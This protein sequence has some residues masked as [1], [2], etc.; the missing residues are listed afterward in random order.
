MDTV[1]S[2]KAT[3]MKYNGTSWEDVGSAGFSAGII[4]YPSISIDSNNTPYVIY[5]DSE[6]GGKVTVMK[7]YAGSWKNV[8]SAGFSVSTSNFSS[9]VIDTNNTPYVVYKD[10]GYGG[11]AVVMKFEEG[12]DILTGTPTAT[13]GAQTS[14][15]VNLTLSDGK[16]GSTIHSFTINISGLNKAPIVKNGLNIVNSVD[17][18][19]SE[20]SSPTPFSLRL[21]ATDEE[22]DTIIWSIDTNASN[23]TATIS[24]STTSSSRTINYI[25][26]K[27]FNGTDSFKVKVIAGSTSIINVNVNVEAEDDAPILDSISSRSVSED[28]SSFNINLNANDV[29]GDIIEYTAT[30]SNPDIA[31]VSIVDGKVIVT[32]KE[33]ANGIVTVTVNA[34]ANGKTTSKNFNVDISEVN[35]TPSI[36]TI[37]SNMTITE[38]NGTISYDVNVSDI[39]GNEL[40]VTVESN[41]TDILKVSPNW[42]GLLTQGQYNEP[43]D[44]NLTTVQDA[45]GI[46]KIT[47]QVVD[48]NNAKVSKSFDINV[49]AVNDAPTLSAISNKV[50][51][52][53]FA[54]K[55][56]TLPL[57]DVDEDVLKYSVNV[58]NTN[59]L[60]TQITN[61]VL[62][63][64]SKENKTGNVDIN[65]TVSDS[66]Y[67]L[68]KVFNFKII[69]LQ[70]ND[71]IKDKGQ[72][73]IDENGTVVVKFEDDNITIKAP[74]K[75]D[76]NGSISHE[77]NID[78]TKVQ[79]MSDINGT[80]VEVTPLGVHTL[81][82][83][84]IHSLTAEVNATVTG[85]ASHSLTKDGKTTKANSNVIGASTTISKDVG[86]IHIKTSVSLDKDKHTTAIVVA[87]EDGSASHEVKGAGFDTIMRSTISGTQTTIEDNNITTITGNK[88]SSCID[89]YIKANVITD[90]DGT[91]KTKFMSYDCTT[92]NS[93]REL[94][95]STDKFAKD[96]NVTVQKN[97]TTGLLEMITITPVDKNIQF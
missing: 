10:Y 96:N 95:T 26:N 34:T 80:K 14:Q 20:D 48:E 81:Y 91:T 1:N 11:K 8:D 33:N 35:D 21:S 78:G 46:V 61:N 55:N 9:I 47:V 22:N 90:I 71:N 50:A 94:P 74:N 86:G 70:I 92:D 44:F 59:L 83:D 56:I 42:S 13:N 60:D 27:N 15:D 67:N 73:Q 51:Y 69:S 57:T 58:E 28:A 43:L 97:T 63:I 5:R 88:P 4:S 66:E 68:S 23:G 19:M 29:D 41:N 76:I 31:T 37:F 6:N 36:D 24:S 85:K 87:N 89:T 45:N 84:N 7:F 75:A 77:I 25:P 3:V 12:S 53:N 18:N 39:D 16:G 32:P 30:S 93:L 65:L 49:S 72:V 40:N 2:K 82:E 62:T 54:D 64:K 79:A 38:D 52:I 17:I